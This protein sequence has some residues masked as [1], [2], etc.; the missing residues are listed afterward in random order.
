VRNSLNHQPIMTL[1]V[2]TT[3]DVRDIIANPGDVDPNLH[4]ELYLVQHLLIQ[5]A[6]VDMPFTPY[7]S[8]SQT[9]KIRKASYQIRS[10]GPPPSSPQ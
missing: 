3:R 4:K 10:K 7:L 8:N 2:D 5:G 1:I 9:K 6:N